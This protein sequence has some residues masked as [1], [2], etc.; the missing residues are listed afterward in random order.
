MDLPKIRSDTRGHRIIHLNNAGASL[1]P[2]PV[3]DAIRDYL[4]LEEYKGGYEAAGASGES[5]LGFYEDAARVL[6]CDS[7]NMAFTTNATDSYNRALSSIPFHSGDVVLISGNDYPSNYIALLSLQKRYGIRL[8]NVRN[9]ATGEMDLNDL[10]EKIKRYSPRL[11]SVTHIPTSSGLVQPAA[12]AGKIIKKYDTV[13]LLDA[14][15]SLGQMDVDAL[16]TQADF[17]SGTFRKF[18]RGPRGAG[19]LYVSAKA[20]AAGYEPLFTDLHGATW[21]TRDQYEPRADA[22]RFEDWETAYALMAGSTEA[23]KYL[24]SIGIGDIETRNDALTSRLRKGL[25]TC[26]N[27]QPADR[28]SR[29]SCIVTFSVPNSSPAATMSYFRNLGMNIY[30]ITK[31]S[32]VLDFEEK[33]IEWV[34]RASPHYYNTETEID[35]FVDAV[36]QL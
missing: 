31:S 14:C 1:M 4:T 13:Y 21:V 10:E 9:N 30:I 19:L 23:L 12:E 28:G 17:I 24:L 15:Q 26:K 22:R 5:L 6:H 20:L 32:A 36:G 3:V 33:G 27:I 7:R 35:A 34:V 11:V 25:A 2:A 16:A 8:V 18:L 29:Q